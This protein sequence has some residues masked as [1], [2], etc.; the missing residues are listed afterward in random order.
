MTA[1]QNKFNWK[2]TDSSDAHNCPAQH[3]TQSVVIRTKICD[4]E[5]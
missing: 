3:L 1:A 5:T 2:F 4:S